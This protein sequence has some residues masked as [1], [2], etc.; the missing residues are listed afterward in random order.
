M[1]RR[2]L[3]TVLNSD[4]TIF[5]SQLSGATGSRCSKVRSTKF[6]TIS[7]GSLSTISAPPG[8]L[9]S[10]ARQ[11]LH[12]LHIPRTL[13]N[14]L[15]DLAGIRRFWIKPH[16]TPQML[17]HAHALL[18][19]Q[20]LPLLQRIQPGAVVGVGV[21]GIQ[22]RGELHKVLRPLGCAVGMLCKLSNDIREILPSEAIGCGDWEAMLRYPCR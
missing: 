3:N 12:E 11:G 14:S 20:C 13:P 18:G 2:V 6:S 15:D 5:L 9:R 1:V 7:P 17:H 4:G 10:S 19:P 8:F 22:I 16:R 21:C